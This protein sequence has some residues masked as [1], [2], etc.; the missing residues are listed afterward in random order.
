MRSKLRALASFTQQPAAFPPAYPRSLRKQIAASRYFATNTLNR[1]FV[2][3]RGFSV[4][5]R[6]ATVP[7]VEREFPGFAPYLAA[8]LRPD[9]NAF[10]LN[11][12]ELIA[13][14]RV[15]PHVDRSLRSYAVH[16]GTPVTVSVLY[17]EV[18]TAMRGGLLVLARGKKQLARIEP[19][20]NLL[21][22]FDGDLTHSVTRMEG[23]GAR[24]S[25]VC[26]Q[27]RLTD[28]ELAEI[29]E[30]AIQTRARYG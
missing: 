23:P 9:C 7:R 25:L 4:V 1:D 24:L 11:P 2:A 30:Y 16:I 8:A 26:E 3:T 19:A 14:S 10:Y 27:Y 5:F 15:D 12:L 20:T 13:A 21:V 18:P 28:A 29:P 22:N 17:V 6:R